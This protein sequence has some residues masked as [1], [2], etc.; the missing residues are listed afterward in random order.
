[1]AT[2]LYIADWDGDGVGDLLAGAA[3]AGLGEA[4]LFLGPLSGSMSA[5]SA[6][7]LFAAETGGSAAGQSVAIVE[8]ID[9][10]GIGEIAIGDSE[11]DSWKLGRA[12]LVFGSTLSP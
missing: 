11:Y 5:Y 2:S 12:S 9:G 8:D 1:P 4:Y 6:D 3:S 10:D 7:Y